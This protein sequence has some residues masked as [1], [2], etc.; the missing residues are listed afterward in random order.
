MLLVDIECGFRIGE[1]LRLKLD[2]LKSNGKSGWYIQYQMHKMNKEHTKPISNELAEVIKEQQAYIKRLF[3]N[4][5]PYLFCGRARQ[6]SK[7]FIPEAK[8]MTSTSF[9]NNL[10]RLIQQFE[11]KEQ[12][13]K[14]W[15]FQTHQFRHTVGTRMINAGVPQHIVQ[16]YLGHES[17]EMTMVY[18]HIFDETLRKFDSTVPR[19]FLSPILFFIVNNLLNLDSYITYPLICRSRNIIEVFQVGC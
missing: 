5:F 11:I 18:A 4:S 15:N 14:L 19:F 7:E 13:G 10:K 3:G 2:C 1:L 6:H 17:P 8:L 12:S 9:I 16:R